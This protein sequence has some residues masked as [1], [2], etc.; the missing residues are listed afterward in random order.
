MAYSLTVARDDL[1][2]KIVEYLSYGRLRG[3]PRPMPSQILLLASLAQALEWSLK[4][5]TPPVIDLDATLVRQNVTLKSEPEL[6]VDRCLLDKI[7]ES[8]AV[9]VTNRRTAPARLFGIPVLASARKPFTSRHR[10]L[11][12][13]MIGCVIGDQYATD[14]LLAARLGIVFIKV[15]PWGRRP[16]RAN[17]MDGML[18]AYFKTTGAVESC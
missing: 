6:S 11:S 12:T 16:L 10:L 9:I 17:I 7:R 2:A 18:S 5:R 1:N 14:G 4:N 15:P 3:I 13:T 8:G